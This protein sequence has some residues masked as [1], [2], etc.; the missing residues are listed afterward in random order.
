MQELFII[1]IIIII[2]YLPSIYSVRYIGTNKAN[3]YI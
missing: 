2:V 1:I 3:S